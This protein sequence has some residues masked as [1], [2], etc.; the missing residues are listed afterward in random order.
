MCVQR[1]DRIGALLKLSK[2]GSGHNRKLSEHIQ[3][4]LIILY[5]CK[6]TQYL[7]SFHPSCSFPKTQ[8]RAY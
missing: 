1:V 2:V 7:V 4:L 3:K 8:T 5:I 6:F